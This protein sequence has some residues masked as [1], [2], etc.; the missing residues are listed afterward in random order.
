MNVDRR[1]HV[2]YPLLLHVS[3]PFSG[4]QTSRSPT[5]TS[6]SLSKTQEVGWPSIRP[7]PGPLGQLKT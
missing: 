4:P 2:E 5:S 6:M 7:P 1:T 3:G